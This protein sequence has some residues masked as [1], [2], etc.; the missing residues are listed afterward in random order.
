MSAR[1]LLAA[2]LLV[3]APAVLAGGQCRGEY[4]LQGNVE[5]DINARNDDLEFKRGRKTVVRITSVPELIIDDRKI[6]LDEPA[7]A[8]LV[9]FRNSYQELLVAAKEIGIAGAKLGGRAAYAM[10]VGLLTG[11]SDEVD[12]KIEAEADK[13]ELQA[14]TLCSVVKRLAAHHDTLSTMIPEFGEALPF[15]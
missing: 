6:T 7:Q 3:A 11:T 10:L 8:E 1:L 13:L 2:A 14:E 12:A 9:A 5:I 4:E 15:K